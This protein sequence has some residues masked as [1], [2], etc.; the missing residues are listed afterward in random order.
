[1]KPSEL[2]TILYDHE[3]WITSG[4]AGGKCA[5]LAGVSLASANLAHISLAGANLAGA[6]LRGA[7]LYKTNLA[8][9]NLA[10]ANLAG[11]SL[12]SAS[13]VGANLVSARLQCYFRSADL[14]CADLVGADL[15]GADLRDTILGGATFA[16][17]FKKVQYFHRA[18]FSEDQIAWVWLHPAYPEFASTLKW[19]KARQLSA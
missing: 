15:V 17:N 5:N 11:A 1:M 19:V 14:R 3:R 18:T 7:D 2:A 8:G 10:G 16:T 9:A 4:E 12:A 6:D 13:L